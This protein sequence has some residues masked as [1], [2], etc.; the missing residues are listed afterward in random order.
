MPLDFVWI[1]ERLGQALGTGWENMD[2]KMRIIFGVIFGVILG[3]AYG[4]VS[5][6]INNIFLPGIP[7][8][9]P[10]QGKFLSI[11]EW[12]VVGGALGFL[13]AWPKEF[14]VGVLISSVIGTLASSFLSL[15]AETGSLANLINASVVIFVSFLPRV[16]IFLPVFILIR[17][18]A[19]TWEQETLYT[20]Y[21]TRG[22]IR[23]VLLVVL[24]G[25][26]AGIF[27]LYSAG[28]RQS[29]AN[30]NELILKGR[31]ASSTS[32]L[33]QALQRVND[34]QNYSYLPYTLNVISDPEEIPVPQ[35]APGYDQNIT[36][37]VVLFSNGF[38]FGCVYTALNQ[39]PNCAAY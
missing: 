3:L 39:P 18:S 32:S 1:N 14:F 21:V 20:P 10:P 7:L 22:R 17:W 38:R 31:Q 9:A 24:V 16:V 15:W 26:L 29:L 35:P 8:Y 13:V 30:L 11:I 19:N 12:M 25:M 6:S 4:L 36:A 33:P 5:L 28:S 37:I 2:D 23:S 34:F 27:S